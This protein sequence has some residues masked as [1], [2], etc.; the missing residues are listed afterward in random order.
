LARVHAAGVVHADVKPGNVLLRQLDE[1][2]LSDFG[3]ARPRGAAGEGGSPGYVSPERLGG[4]PMDPRDDIYGFGRILEDVLHVLGSRA[5]QGGVSS[6][7]SVADAGDEARW[8]DLAA[9]CI[10][11]LEQRP[12]DGSEL[13]HA[14][15]RVA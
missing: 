4:A 3:I 5:A 13:V 10:G 8:R 14:L 6:V 1:P 15:P 7:S 9:R 11:P 12:S 2:V